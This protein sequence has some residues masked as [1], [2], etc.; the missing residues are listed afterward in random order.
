MDTLRVS[1]LI[2]GLAIIFGIYFI[3]R[4]Y[5]DDEDKKLYILP[6]IPWAELFSRLKPLFKM[7]AVYFS[8]WRSEQVATQ[9]PVTEE[10][11][12]EDIESLNHII[13]DRG[14]P[15]DVEVDDVSVIVELTADQIAPAGEQLFIPVTIHGHLGR[16]F[17]GEAIMYATGEL[18]MVL[19]DDGVFRYKVED[20]QGYKQSLLGLA[21]IVE[22]GTFDSDNMRT[23]ET[24]GLVL[25]LNLPGPV[26][27]RQAFDKLISVGRK[28]ADLLGGDFCDE[29]RSV[30]TNQT[31][32]HLKEKVEAFRFK[33][34]MTQLKQRRP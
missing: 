18:D 16:R 6:Q 2:I 4:R 30:L 15:E 28:L 25:Y 7:P 19:G 22:P 5:L 33:Q 24:P 32:S 12:A 11:A 21:N 29:T 14:S 26:E 27:P 1:L 3:G 20:V 34:K 10:L 17:T 13:T 8:R 9:P 31:I 23:F